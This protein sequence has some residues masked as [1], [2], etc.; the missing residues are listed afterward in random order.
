MSTA[1]GDFLYEGGFARDP[2][3]SSLV[4]RD[5]RSHGA[6]G[7][8]AGISGSVQVP[9]DARVI[10]IAASAG[11]GAG[12]V[13]IDGGDAF[14]VAANSSV[15]ITPLGNIVAPLLIFDATDSYFVEYVI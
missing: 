8:R 6:Y 1:D 11:A 2:Q 4:T 13:V 10:G 7:Y 3:D 9:P 5:A 12:S 14:P 15:Q